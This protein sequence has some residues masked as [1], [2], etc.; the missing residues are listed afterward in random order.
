MGTPWIIEGQI[1]DR[2][3]INTRGNVG[4]VFPEVI[5]AL[6]YHLGVVTA[7]K[8]WR[9]A[10]R[11]L[12]ILSPGD[13]SSDDPVIIGLYGG[14]CYLNLSYLRMMG[15]RA[16][17]SSAEAI[18][19]AF[20]GEGNPPPYVPRKGDKSLGSTLRILRTV[21]K[22]LGT[23]ALPEL[24][25]DSFRRAAA[26]EA[27]RPDLDAPDSEL[28]DY[29][30]AFPAA[31]E[32]LFANHMQSTALAAIVSG[33]LADASSAAGNPGLVT[34][35]V[36]AA[37]D[38]R[39]AMY[40]TDLYEIA[41]TVR[42]QPSLMAAFD[43][44]LDG[45]QE[46]LADDPDAAGLRQQLAGFLDT[47]GHR[48]PNDWELSSRTW[49]NTP[50]LVLVAIDRMRVAEHDLTPGERLSHD[51][52]RRQAAA[53]VVRPHLKFMDRSN[54]DKA[55]RASP[56]WSQAREATRDRAVR[57]M[58][59]VKQ[60]YRELV[61]RSVERG[62]TADPTQVALLDP[63]TE[64]PGY[65]EDPSA[66]ACLVAERSDLHRRFAAVEPPFFISSQDEVPTIEEL[67]ATRAAVSA[68]GVAGPGD[69]LTG[70]GGCS[71]VA[72]GRARIVLDP[73]DAGDLEPGDVLVA[74][75]TDPS[76]T[77][78]FLPA[79]AVVVNVGA[80]MS[81]AVIVARELA[82]PCVVA[83]ESATELIP[84]GAMVEVDGTA[85]T[86]TLL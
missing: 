49:D 45:L 4:E 16:P 56:F 51:D 13:F 76:W 25:A 72:R 48:G 19:I 46:R 80:L 12:G 39:S 1:D 41:R 77:P 22:A 3:P 14:Y 23:K 81:H 85:G 70:A 58:L 24:V 47:H 9:A 79:A 60:V 62:G 37:G 27:E 18:D 35:L 50:G 15:V 17:G 69:V 73:G 7:E 43:D 28:L 44:G 5:T 63:Y 33:V 26:F 52:E 34:H 64:L 84:D 54:F 86:V 20:F 8:A 55:L 66:M 6:G 67:E 71:G 11:D 57:M 83:V 65:L 38:V 61:R 59:P 42:S 68:V 29:L 30:Y 10:Y 82:I 36:G 75:L 2:W 31:F 74:P 53:A 32:P 40:A 21:L 78:L